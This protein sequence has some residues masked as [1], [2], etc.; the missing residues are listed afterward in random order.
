MGIR[1]LARV[2]I[3]GLWI[4]AIGADWDQ[5]CGSIDGAEVSNPLSKKVPIY[6]AL[7]RS[8]STGFTL[9]QLIGLLIFKTA[10]V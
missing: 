3:F 7:I 5:R 9:I 1:G 6:L 10:V 4:F 8:A 2:W